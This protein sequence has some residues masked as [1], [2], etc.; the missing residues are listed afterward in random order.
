MNILSRLLKVLHWIIFIY[1]SFI[2]LVVLVNILT[3]ADI[4]D[5][6]EEV[7]QGMFLIENAD[8]LY[9]G[10]P[11]DLSIIMPFIRYIIFGRIGWFPWTPFRKD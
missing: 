7:A 1:T 5:I 3:G 9:L 2:I 4:E 11:I 8:S 6:L 10:V